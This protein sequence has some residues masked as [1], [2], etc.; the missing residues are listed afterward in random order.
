M[1]VARAKQLFTV[2]VVALASACSVFPC[3]G[4]AYPACGQSSVARDYLAQIKREA[5]ITEVPRSGELPFGKM[6]QAP[7]GMRL[8]AIGSTPIVDS[9]EVGF[10]LSNP[11]TDRRR[12]DWT[13]E[14]ELVKVN[15]RGRTIESL[16][17]KRRRIG[18]VQES[19]SRKFLFRVAAMPAYYRTDI[20]FV[21][22]GTKPPLGE[23]SAYVR[24]MRPRVDLRVKIDSRS[25]APGEVA[26]ATVLNLGTVPLV[27]RTYDF[28]FAVQ[29]FTGEKWIRVPDNPQRRIPKRLGPWTL[30]PG[31]ENR[32]CLRYLV[33]NDQAPGL[34]RFIAIGEEAKSETL[35]AEF[36]VASP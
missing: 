30:S 5:P 6:P 35:A 34:F 22:K 16:G 26:S 2:L 25:V 17:I 7:T 12:L 23:Y 8:E 13:V 28:G 27:T 1:I 19:A 9:G 3:A 18:V 24:V 10:S 14:S 15:A 36:Q 20:R 31:A 21:A 4:F 33:P 11:A 29:A 32:G